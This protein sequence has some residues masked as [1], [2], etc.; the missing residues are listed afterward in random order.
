MTS[1]HAGLEQERVAKLEQ[2]RQAEA[3]AA[4][5]KQRR[6]AQTRFQTV[7]RFVDETMRDLNPTAALVW[8]V[9]WR[10]ERKGTA[11]A[12]LA[13]LAERTGRSRRAV[14]YAL[15]E[16]RDAGLVKQIRR[17]APGGQ[18]NVYRI[19]PVSGRM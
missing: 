18:P 2:I 11:S 1:R 10:D 6:K 15:R 8:L 4:E 16:L 5:K 9:L 13:D 17:G 3:V 7:N 14:V 12:S 19:R